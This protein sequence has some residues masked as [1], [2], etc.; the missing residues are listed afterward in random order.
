VEY[1]LAEQ[2]L[3]FLVILVLTVFE[4]VRDAPMGLSAKHAMSRDIII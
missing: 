3:I 2:E 4:D 1:V